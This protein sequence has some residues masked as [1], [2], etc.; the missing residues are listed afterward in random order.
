MKTTFLI[1]CHFI[2]SC[3]AIAQYSLDW[4]K[5]LGG[6]SSDNAY[7]IHLT[8]D[9]GYILAGFT[10]SNNNGDVS[11]AH[12]GG[13]IWV[14]K[15]NH[16]GT[17][18]WQ[19]VLGGSSTEIGYSIKQTSEGGYIVAGNT[20][21]N[22]GDIS[23]QHGETDCWVVKLS[24]FGSIE[25]QKALGGS[26]RDEAHC[27]EQTSDGGYILAGFSLSNDGDVSANY[28]YFDGWF[29][30]LDKTG[31]IE[32][33]KSYGGNSGSDKIYSIQQTNDGGY[34]A[35]GE[36]NSTD[37]EFSGNHGGGDIWIIKLSTLG[38][39]QWQ[40][41]IGG[42]GI[43]AGRSICQTFDGGYIVTGVTGSGNSGDVTG[44]HGGFDNWVVKLNDIGEIEWQK[45]YGGSKHDYGQDI[46]Q[47]GDNG[48]FVAGT[49]QSI[50]GDVQNNDGSQDFWVIKIDSLGDIQWENC[51]G[52]T[53]TEWANAM[54]AA[55]DGGIAVAGYSYSN[56]GDVSGNHGGQD[57]W[58]V[59]LSPENT[60]ATHTPQAPLSI[61]PN[62]AHTAATLQIPTAESTLQVTICDL[63]GRALSRQTVPNGGQ[64]D[65]SGLPSGLYLVSAATESGQVYVGKLCKE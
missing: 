29:V 25:W 22:D 13:D 47:T 60:S 55:T 24:N 40:K 61:H 49:T 51:F 43:E 50:D 17:L 11:E 35:V 33:E 32:W 27:I 62:P 56:D 59:K 44:N 52:G 42:S 6:N 28:G 30:K 12:G 45:T 48:Y 4:Q 10:L 14:V 46:F 16:G 36:T 5:S 53:N 31:S 1:F 20:N 23:G 57:F 8:N 19:V 7:A 63:L 15:T 65:V 9:G 54:A 41:T 58:I 2:I 64:A 37:G 18:E 34:I 21:S 3:S 39:T 38:E 26:N